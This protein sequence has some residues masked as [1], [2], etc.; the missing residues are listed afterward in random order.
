MK[1]HLKNTFLLLPIAASLPVQAQ[2][3]NE[4]PNLVFIMAD[5]WRGDA[6][7]CLDKEPVQTPH[8]DQLASEGVLFTNAVSC[9]P[10]SSPARG[11]LMSGMYPMNNKVIGNC[12]LW[13]GTA[14]NSPLLE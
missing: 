3:K 9:Y 11:I 12:P 2:D 6:L 5:Q 10:V 4:S 14:G 13:C 1:Q 7:G 8:L